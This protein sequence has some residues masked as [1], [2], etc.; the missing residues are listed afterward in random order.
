MAVIEGVDEVGDGGRI[1]YLVPARAVLGGK[2]GGAHPHPAEAE[3]VEIV[4]HRAILGPTRFPFHPGADQALGDLL[5]GVAQGGQ[6]LRGGQGGRGNR[7]NQDGG[8]VG[9]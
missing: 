3:L 4:G 8:H 6:A 5:N 7:L 9:I 1:H 2:R